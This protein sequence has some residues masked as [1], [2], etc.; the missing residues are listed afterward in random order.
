MMP[1]WHH[2]LPVQAVQADQR[3]PAVRQTSGR[4]MRI[5]HASRVQVAVAAPAVVSVAQG[6][7]TAWKTALSADSKP[8]MHEV[9][10]CRVGVSCV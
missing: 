7:C 4:G 3:R 5:C 10:R 6:L 1:T 2:L 8:T 9:C